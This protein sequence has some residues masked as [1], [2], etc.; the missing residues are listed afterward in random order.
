[1][2]TDRARE[3]LIT[4]DI[5]YIDNKLVNLTVGT[6]TKL[7]ATFTTIITLIRITLVKLLQQQ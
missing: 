1:M 7:M 4:T 5:R 2:T 6:I 3:L